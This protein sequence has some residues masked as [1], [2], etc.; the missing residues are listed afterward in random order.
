MPSV[1]VVGR[2]NLFDW[3]DRHAVGRVETCWTGL[4]AVESLSVFSG[5]I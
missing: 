2:V 3:F 4:T 5:V 1:H